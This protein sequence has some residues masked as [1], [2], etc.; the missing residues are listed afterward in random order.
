MIQKTLL[1]C[2]LFLNWPLL[3]QSKEIEITSSWPQWRGPDR[4]GIIPSDSPWPAKI[5]QKSL[6]EKWRVKLGKG[7]SG[8]V[9][10]NEMVYTTESLDEDEITH[11]YNRKDGE[12]IW[13]AKWKGKMKV[14]FFAAKNGSWIRSTPTFDGTNL[15]VCGM[16]DVLYSLNAK[17]G[18]INWKVDFVERY[19]TPLP[20]FGMVCS[21]LI[22]GDDLYVQAG[23]GF[24]KLD[25]RNGKSIWR[26]LQDKGGMFGSAFSSPVIEE[27]NGKPQVVVQTRTD[28]A[29][30]NPQNGKELWK[31]PIKAFRGMNILTP[32]V[33][34]NSIF[35]SSYGGKSLLFEVQDGEKKQA[36]A[37]SWENRQEGYM[38]GPIILDGYCYIHL[39]KQRITCLDMKTG[40]TQ[41]ISS[42]SFGKYMSMIS[43]GKEILALDEDGTLYLIEPNPEK[44]VIK[45]SRKISESPTWAHLAVADN[46][47]FVRELEALV[48]Y[49]W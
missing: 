31:K 49:S 20:A 7:Y 25:K 46:Q 21:P 12:L 36:L 29:A 2:T 47:I 43:N 33:I 19:D 22:D 6:K 34:G 15:Y 23:S 41:W 28:L 10:S 4:N 45:E 30:V 1:L 18:A 11:A 14:P 40:E 13:S 37:Q 16:R 27:I 35:T 24:V 39:R 32:T 17:T 26:S 42:E 3:G 9:V 38:S 8:P 5:G 44:F 48:C